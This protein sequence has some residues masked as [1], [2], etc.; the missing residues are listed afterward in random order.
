VTINQILRIGYFIAFVTQRKT[1]L[2]T[3]QWYSMGF[4]LRV[5]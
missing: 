1:L 2:F 3:L 4:G 5:I